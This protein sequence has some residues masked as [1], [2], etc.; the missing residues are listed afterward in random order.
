LTPPLATKQ[1]LIQVDD[2]NASVKFLGWVIAVFCFD[3]LIGSPLIGFWGEKRPTREPL[4]IA[5][6][7]DVIFHVLYSYCGGFPSGLAGWIMLVSRAMVGFAT[8]S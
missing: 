3:Q 5:L 1:L 6:L 7:I 8:G 4:I 2:K